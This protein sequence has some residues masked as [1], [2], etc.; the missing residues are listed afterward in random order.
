MVRG[1][2]LFRPFVHG[3]RTIFRSG[4]QSRILH[5]AHTNQETSEVSQQ[6]SAGISRGRTINASKARPTFRIHC[7][8][9][10]Y[11]LW[12]ATERLQGPGMTF[13]KTPARRS[14][15]NYSRSTL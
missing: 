5:T 3:D 2:I 15:F 13:P 8:S 10:S 11:S 1:E 9:E 12:S 6:D 4:R 14:Y 7:L